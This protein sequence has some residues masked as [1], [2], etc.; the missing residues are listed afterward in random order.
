M[1]SPG[2]IVW[3]D[4]EDRENLRGGIYLKVHEP[5]SL[6]P[7]VNN[8]E[9]GFDTFENPNRSPNPPD[10][11]PNVMFNLEGRIAP[12]EGLFIS[13][14]ILSVPSRV[15]TEYEFWQGKRSIRCLCRIWFQ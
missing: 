5:L 9:G 4:F 15:L 3:I 10:V 1:P 7:I 13:D 6:F 14:P 2:D 8:L 12:E 11:D